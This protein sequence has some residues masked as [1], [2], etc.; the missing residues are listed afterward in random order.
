VFPS[1]LIGYSF[2]QAVD[3]V[4]CWREQFSVP[5]WQELSSFYGRRLTGTR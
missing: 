1:S 4:R 5:R 3:L 2:Q